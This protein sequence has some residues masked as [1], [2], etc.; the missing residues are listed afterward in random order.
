MKHIKRL[1]RGLKVIVPIAV[2]ML[3]IAHLTILLLFWGGWSVFIGIWLLSILIGSYL[4]GMNN[5]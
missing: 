4:E 1:L 3:I 2:G 5:E